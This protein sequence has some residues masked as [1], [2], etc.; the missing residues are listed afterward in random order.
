MKIKALIL[1]M[2]GIS[3]QPALAETLK[4][5]IDKLDNYLIRSGFNGAVLVACKGKKIYSRAYGVA[6]IEGKE[7]LTTESSFNL[8]S[9]SK[10]FTAT[11]IMILNEKK[12]LKLSDSVSK[13]LPEL[14]YAKGVTIRHL[15]NHTSGLPDIYN[16]LRSIWDRKKIAANEDLLRIFK[17]R[18]PVLLFEPGER[19]RYSNTGYILL[20]SIIEAVSGQSF[21]KFMEENIFKPLGMQ[22]TYAYYRTMKKYPHDSR[23]WGMR[24]HGKKYVL[25]DLIYCDGM[26]GD[27]N[28]HSSAE[29]LFK[30][31]RALY[32][33]KILKKSSIKK[34]F[35]HGILNN[36]KKILYGCGWGLNRNG[37]V[38][39]HGGR[40]VG[41]RSFIIRYTE[42]ESTIVVLINCVSPGVRNVVERLKRDL[43]GKE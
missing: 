1:I 30:W 15:L 31:D 35:A 43:L 3:L 6:D 24:K 19:M 8:A 11:G 2:I 4:E 14:S 32:T 42:E 23:V 18:E 26:R 28:I 21:Y 38:V 7:K 17:K 40:W 13:Y 36:G 34:M 39:S 20:A 27:G 5:R 10:P 41:F 16:I 33:E 9:V 29:D 22:N 12:K 25:N 37:T